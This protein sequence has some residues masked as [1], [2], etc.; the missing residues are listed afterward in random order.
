M[1]LLMTG[2]KPQSSGTGGNWRV[3]V[4][5]FEMPI[6]AQV[7]AVLYEGRDPRSAIDDLMAWALVQERP[8]CRFLMLGWAPCH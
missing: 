5:G 6:T 3:A 4:S 8:I 1:M 2:G 7:H